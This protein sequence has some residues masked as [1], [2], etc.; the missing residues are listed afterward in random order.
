MYDNE[1]HL[2]PAGTYPSHKAGGHLFEIPTGRLPHSPG[3]DKFG[4]VPSP[5]K[6]DRIP[7]ESSDATWEVTNEPAAL[8]VFKDDRVPHGELALARKNSLE[9]WAPLDANLSSFNVPF[10]LPTVPRETWISLSFLG[11]EKLQVQLSETAAT[12]LA[13]K[14]CVSE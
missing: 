6:L 2:Q 14:A 13:M 3:D 11:E 7:S 8:R 4:D 1:K 10:F 9:E 5:T 12:D